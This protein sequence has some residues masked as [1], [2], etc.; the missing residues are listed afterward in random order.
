MVLS[1]PKKVSSISSMTNQTCHFGIMGGL[2]PSVGLPAGARMFR[3]RRAKNKQPMPT[4]CIPGLEYMKEHDILS[5]NPAG[6]G[7]IGLTKVL[8]DRS[9]GPCN[10]SGGGGAGGVAGLGSEVL[11]LGDGDP[12]S[13]LSSCSTCAGV[14]KVEGVNDVK[15]GWCTGKL[16]DYDDKELPSKCG[17][18][19]G[20]T[21]YSTY[22]KECTG[23][24]IKN[25][26]SKPSPPTGP[27]LH[28]TL[29][30]SYNNSTGKDIYAKDSGILL[31]FF[32]FGPGKDIDK[33]MG[34]AYGPPDSRKP[35]SPTWTAGDG[36]CTGLGNR[37]NP[38]LSILCP[39]YTGPTLRCQNTWDF[40]NEYPFQCIQ[41]GKVISF[42]YIRHDL[43]TVFYNTW[44][45]ESTRTK[46]P[47]EYMTG[48]KY[49]PYAIIYDNSSGGAVNLSDQ[50]FC[51][52]PRDGGT[53]ARAEQPGSA[54]GCSELSG[55]NLPFCSKSM[56]STGYDPCQ[57]TNMLESYKANI[58]KKKKEANFDK[59]S[60]SGMYNEVIVKS[61][62]HDADG[63][64]GS[65][66]SGNWTEKEKNAWGWSDALEDKPILAFAV[67]TDPNVQP[68]ANITKLKGMLSDTPFA[69]SI[70]SLDVS[71]VLGKDPF[72][73]V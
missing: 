70:V 71:A 40:D 24:E 72:S 5:K 13:A 19:I 29:N 68:S 37:P 45:A 61:W 51:S 2:A 50:L 49:G 38:K 35:I 28:Q 32:D 46:S 39:P 31:S 43:A 20:P 23:G 30:T 17:G 4:G 63:P 27:P 67:R 54:P 58:I 53:G 16:T 11:D 44:Q 60:I 1:G 26:C 73:A 34:W 36:N 66:N 22:Y 15:C 52:Y 12:C 21:W 69:N 48:W 62:N 65:C 41:S 9:M 55:L 59:L 57:D 7:G 10:C 64:S 33:N 42:S 25:T 14:M 3:L 6:S 56:C 47:L 18:A 8:V